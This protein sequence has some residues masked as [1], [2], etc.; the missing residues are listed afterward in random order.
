MILASFITKYISQVGTNLPF[1]RY[2]FII[3]VNEIF[4]A[5]PNL[6][7]YESS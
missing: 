7:I 3:I 1:V 2:V 4:A 5:F 6:I